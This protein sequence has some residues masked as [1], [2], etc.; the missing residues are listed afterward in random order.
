[1][2]SP[3]IA[4]QRL[5]IL[6]SAGLVA[7]LVATTVGVSGAFIDPPS[8]DHRVIG[9]PTQ[10]VD[11]ITFFTQ[12]R[13][14]DCGVSAEFRDGKSLWV[15]CDPVWRDGNG[16]LVL[17]AVSVAPGL[18]PSDD[19]ADFTVAT[20]PYGF[21]V[22]FIPRTGQSCSAGVERSWVLGMTSWPLTSTKDR[23]LVYFQD[24]CIGPYSHKRDGVATFDY[25]HGQANNHSTMVATRHTAP[26]A[27]Q[28]HMWSDGAVA[29]FSRPVY[30]PGDDMVY[31]YNCATVAGCEVARIAAD[32]SAAADF[33]DLD[34]YEYWDGTAWS[35]DIGDAIDVFPEDVSFQSNLVW[36]PRSEHFV[37]TAWTFG[38]V[39]WSNTFYLWSA[40]SPTGP[41]TRANVY[42]SDGSQASTDLIEMDSCDDD[43]EGCYA[44]YPHTEQST[45]F[46]QWVSYFDGSHE[47]SAKK[48]EVGN[49]TYCI[50][51]AGSA[52]TFDDIDSYYTF[53][54][55]IMT[56][57]NRCVAY[58]QVD[59]NFSPTSNVLRQEATAFIYRLAGYP[60]FTPPG[61]PSYSDVGTSHPLYREIEW[62][63]AEGIIGGYGDGTFKPGI[64]LTRQGAAVMLFKMSDNA[65][66]P[67]T[68]VEKFSDVS[69]SHLFWKQIHWAADEGLINGYGDGTFKPSDA[70]T[71]AAMAAFLHR[72]LDGPGT[73]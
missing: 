3:L 47:D 9:A 66:L 73:S 58:G 52:S 26:S 23:V 25:T 35:D 36:N 33:A 54:A 18:A 15:M 45:A 64:A 34:S 61:T 60:E 59:G 44:F 43:D 27:S 38:D 21:P 51:D 67:S 48:L 63:T 1:M 30:N 41:W 29:S 28:T 10:V 68:Y 50:P 16:D 39:G 55:E 12:E 20:N 56:L 65:T 69:S 32:Q 57:V 2:S 6:V 7:L 24:V 40:P 22:D 70:T 71:R 13:S 8:P 11:E 4:R 62:A 17:G 53:Y 37:L 19:P 31:V 46:S 5:H 72:W 49:V 14:G 42:E